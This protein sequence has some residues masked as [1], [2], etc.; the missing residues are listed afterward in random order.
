MSIPINVI[1]ICTVERKRSGSFASFKAVPAD[2][3]PFF[4]SAESFDL[5]A[6]IRA[7]SDMEKTPFN[8]IN[9]IIIIISSI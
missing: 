3:L 6:D 2:L 5:R 8:I 9:P 4:A 1:P 7:T